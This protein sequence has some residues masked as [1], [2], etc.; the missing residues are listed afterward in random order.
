MELEIHMR[1]LRA[2]A[3][4]AAM[5]GSISMV[6]AGVASAGGSEPPAAGLIVACTQANG[7]TI[8]EGDVDAPLLGA[9]TGG[10]G[11]ADSRAQQ[12]NCGVGVEENT[13]TSGAA[14]G[15]DASGLV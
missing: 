2:A 9:L 4:T 10:G 8:T 3:V 14:T 5:V 1:K 12:N 6:G 15:G 11:D 7:D 13:N